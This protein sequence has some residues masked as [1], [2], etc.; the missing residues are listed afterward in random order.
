MSDNDHVGG[1]LRVGHGLQCGA[2]HYGGHDPR[3]LVW[4][5]ATGKYFVIDKKL[6]VYFFGFYFTWDVPQ[7]F[8]EFQIYFCPL[9]AVGCA[10]SWWRRP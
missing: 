4:L 6:L 7:K 2:T 9:A 5:S 1:S 8:V 3:L 10:S